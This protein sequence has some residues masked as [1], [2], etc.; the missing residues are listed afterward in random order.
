L[1]SLSDNLLYLR[2]SKG[3]AIKSETLTSGSQLGFKFTLT[4]LS[5]R[6]E[7]PENKFLLI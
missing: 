4:L 2:S 3:E 1:S 6:G 5:T 7:S